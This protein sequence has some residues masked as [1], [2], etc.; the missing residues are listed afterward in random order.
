MAST[1]LTNRLT[2]RGHSGQIGYAAAC[3]GGSTAVSLVNE[4]LIS[5]DVSGGTL[6]IRAKPFINN[7]TTKQLNGGTLLINP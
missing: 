2:L 6:I 4:A 5:A 1:T 7:G 3:I